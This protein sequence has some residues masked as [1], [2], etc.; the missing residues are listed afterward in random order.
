MLDPAPRRY[1]PAVTLLRR[2]ARGAAAAPA[3]SD[4]AQLEDWLLGDALGED[5]MLGFFERLVWGI[6]AAGIP[7]DRASLHAGTLHPLLYGYAWNWNRA[8][9]LCDET[10]VAEAVLKTEAYRSNPIF[11]V[12]EYGRGFR[13]R[14][15]DAEMRERYPL[16]AD[17]AAQGIMDYSILPLFTGATYHNAVTIAT[18]APTGFSAADYAQLERILRLVSGHVQ[19]H[20]AQQITANVLDTYLGPAAGARVLRGNIQRGSGAAIRAIIWSSDLRGFTDLSDRLSGDDM[21]AVLNAY[22]ERMVAA[23]LAQGG[24]VLKFIGDG[25]LAVFPYSAFADEA[26]ASRAALT[27][28]QAALASIRALNDDPPPE[29]AA[30]PHW[31][32][33]HSGIGLHEGDVF[34]GNVGAAQRLDF[35]VIGRAV[36]TAAR[37][38]G[39]SKELRRDILLTEPVAAR[40]GLD[41]KNGGLDDLGLHSLRGLQVPIRLFS[42]SP[43]TI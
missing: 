8:D 22:F 12:I 34:F 31:R 4:S 15:D 18:K 26:A 16:M 6:V 36:N 40:I 5:D 37:V 39:L 1:P 3:I 21:I 35:T 24:E 29:L 25:L 41:S 23:I 20:V 28:A 43:H 33:L 32:P 13:G 10:V 42:P 19:R 27:A 17:L 11:Q 38:E 14:T 2:A 7:L 9:G 30:L